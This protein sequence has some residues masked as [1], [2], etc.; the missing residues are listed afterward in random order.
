[1]GSTKVVAR[2]LKEKLDQQLK[3]SLFSIENIPADI[4]FNIYDGFILGYPVYHTH[5]PMRLLR[6][7]HTMNL[8]D[9]EK[10]AFIFNTRGLYSAN[11]QRILAKYL[12]KKNIKIIMDKEYRSPA[13]DISLILPFIKQVWCFEKRIDDRIDC[14]SKLFAEMIISGKY[15]YYMPRFRL[16]SLLNAP[17]K[18]IG[19]LITL[20]IYLH[21][22][23]CVKC[24][25]CSVNCPAKAQIPGEDKYPVFYKK[26]CE[27]CFRCIH[28][29]PTHALSLSK[30][31]TPKR[32]M[33]Y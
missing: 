26:K 16:Y 28:Q 4:K 22:K 14:H 12:I 8:L 33:T 19:Q 3:V 24:G 13:S 10:P 21:K 29:C 32:V 17:N 23:K 6:F 11:S 31:K 9:T 25:K 2:Q 27:K 20:P 7:I 18:L 15:R 1:M 30:G 5:P